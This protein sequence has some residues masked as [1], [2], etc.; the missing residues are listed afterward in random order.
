MFMRRGQCTAKEQISNLLWNCKVFYHVQKSQPIYFI[1]SQLNLVH[2]RTPLDWM[3]W[4]QL[5]RLPTFQDPALNEISLFFLL[6]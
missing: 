3:N 6:W 2:P 5:K 1:L 4:L